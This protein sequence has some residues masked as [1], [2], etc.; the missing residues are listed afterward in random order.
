MGRGAPNRDGISGLGSHKAYGH[1]SLQMFSCKPLA[2]E[3]IYRVL[4][5]G[6]WL[7]LSVTAVP[8]QL[9]CVLGMFYVSR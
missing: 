6:L 2:T 7:A 1:L 3:G 5:L 9:V 8:V 4:G